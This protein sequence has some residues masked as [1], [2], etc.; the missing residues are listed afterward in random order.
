MSRDMI[1]LVAL[2]FVLRIVFRGVMHMALVVKV[3]GVDRHD[4][5]RHPAR[6]GIPAYVIADLESLSH[7]VDS[8]FL[9]KARLSVRSHHCASRHVRC[10]VDEGD[11]VRPSQSADAIQFLA[12]LPKFGPV[13]AL[14]LRPALGIMPEPLPQLG[15][16][17]DLLYP[18][19]ERG[20][21]FAQPSRPES[22]DKDPCAVVG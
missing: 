14:E 9:P 12:V 7:L 19:I 6:L 1:G 21:F 22:I 20:L 16:R 15:G 11:R 8:S 3:S 2:D 17:G 10:T 5:A 13:A 18:F 4:G